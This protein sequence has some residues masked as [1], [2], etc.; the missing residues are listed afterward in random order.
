MS[1]GGLK[2]EIK[3]IFLNGLV[4][5]I[6]CWRIREILYKACGVSIGINS[7]ILLGTRIMCPEKV[8]I[9]ANTIINEN[10]VL[11]GRGG[12]RIGDNVS[13]SIE[14]MI[15]TGTH[16]TNSEEYEGVQFPVEIGDNAWLCARA[17]ILPGSTIEDFSIIA[18][19]AVFKGVAS[20]KKIYGGVPAKEIGTRQINE[21]Y[22]I[23]WAPLMR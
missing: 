8:K 7:R 16:A 2:S 10:C 14:S 12:L 5:K 4:N 6:P 23:R 20:A 19:G 3:Y 15:L 9:G 11:D 17:I 13:I 18:A 22:V 21:K 1:L